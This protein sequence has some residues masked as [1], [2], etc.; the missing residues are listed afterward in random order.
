MSFW[1]F[2]PSFPESDILW[3]ALHKDS[4]ATYIKST[5]LWIF[6][7]LLSVVLLT[8]ILLIN[9]SS[10]IIENV[11]IGREWMANP[12]FNTYLTTAMTMTM[13]VILIPFFIDIMVMI[14]DHKTKSSR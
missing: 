9:M 2:Y 12:K 7:L 8:P 10:N 1:Q 5:I 14:E 4:L 11:D 13:N 3:N 6:L